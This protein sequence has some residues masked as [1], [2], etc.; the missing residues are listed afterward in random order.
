MARKTIIAGNWKM[1]KTVEESVSLAKDVVAAVGN[2]EDVTVAVCPP[3]TSLYA[4]SEVLKGSNV[5]LGA[6]DVHWEKSGAFTGKIS[7]DMLKSCN[8]EVVILGHSE[9]RQYFGETNETVNKKVIATLE[10][11]LTPIICVG[12]TLEERESGNME[13]VVKDHVVGGYKGLSKDDALKTVIAYEPVWAIGTGVTDSPEQAEE[14]HAFIRTVLSDLYDAE[15]AEA[16][17]IQYGGSMKPGNAK[18]LLGKDNVD[19][20]LIGGAA[21]DAE[22]FKGIVI[23]A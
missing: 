8:V 18:E 19:G 4:V 10:G 2:V 20:G 3:Y 5:K 14:V 7:I 15:V 21:L 23:P 11:G 1:N 13:K 12:E 17:Q 6:Q 22:Q 16:L 9:Q